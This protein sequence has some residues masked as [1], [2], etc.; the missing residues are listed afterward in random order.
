MYAVTLYHQSCVAHI[1]QQTRAPQLGI[2]L[3]LS[4]ILP[5]LFWLHAAK[6]TKLIDAENPD[7]HLRHV[8]LENLVPCH[9]K[10]K[11]CRRV[12]RSICNLAARLLGAD[13]IFF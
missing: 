2:P 12:F 6:T 9:D 3:F 10:P 4:K 13:V 5:N 8:L 1:T 11:Y 7:A